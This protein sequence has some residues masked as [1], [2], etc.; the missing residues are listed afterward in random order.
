MKRLR[1]PN[2]LLFMGAVASPQHLCIVTEFLPCGSLYQLL[3]RG[4][5]K[6][7]CRR[8]VLMALDIARGMNYL[9]LCNPPIV[10]RDLKS[11]NLLVD[12]NW[13]VK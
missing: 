1:H 10:H 13:T 2:V 8:R 11:S 6:L 4:S 3:Q 5:Q 12:K 7:D 9:H